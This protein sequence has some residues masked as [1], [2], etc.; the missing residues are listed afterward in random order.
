VYHSDGKGILPFLHQVIDERI[1]GRIRYTWLPEGESLPYVPTE[2]LGCVVFLGY[3]DEAGKEQFVGSAFWV[4]RLG[5]E[6]IKKEYRP[7]YLVT[8]AHVIN[9][10]RAKAPSRRVLVRVNTRG[11]GQ[12]WHATP[13]DCWRSHPDERVDIAVFK[14]D[15]VGQ[16]WDHFAWGAEAFV[17]SQSAADDGGRAIGHGDDVVVAG[18]FYLHTGEQRN[19]PIVRVANVAALRGEPVLDMDA[20]LVECHSIGGHSGSP[21]FYDVYATKNAFV[22]E[23]RAVKTM[24]KWRLLG[25]MHGHFDFPDVALDV[26]VEDSKEKIAINSGIAIVIPAEKIVEALDTFKDEEAKEAERFRM[27]KRS[28]MIP[29]K[30]DEPP[31]TEVRVGAER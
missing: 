8:A 1:A 22:G 12:K 20:Y 30:L 6:D 24:V 13:L 31:P 21:V 5:P 14:M 11:G 10:I 29:D 3:E 4:A 27:K 9:G 17:N 26:V 7:T 2:L 28:Y 19:I 25:V 16:N 15:L 23:S 18:L